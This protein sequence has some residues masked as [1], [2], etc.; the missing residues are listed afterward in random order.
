M[1]TIKNPYTGEVVSSTPFI[2]KE[3]ALSLLDGLA[4]AQ[5]AW[6]AKSLA[7]RIECVKAGA[8]FLLSTSERE[9]YMYSETAVQRMEW[10]AA[11]DAVLQAAVREQLRRNARPPVRVVVAGPNRTDAVL[12][13]SGALPP[14]SEPPQLLSQPFVDTL[15]DCDAGL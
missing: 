9:L 15:R 14:R 6:A 8:S 1:N 13:L 5:K 2:S 12:A 7:S 4:V 3:E 11:L 10:S